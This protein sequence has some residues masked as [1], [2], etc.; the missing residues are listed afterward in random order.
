MTRP[1]SL[2]RKK[3]KKNLRKCRD[4]PRSWFGRIN[5][6][7]K[8]ILPKAIYRINAMPTT[9]LTQFFKDMEREIL[10]FIWKRQTNKQKSRI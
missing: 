5:I 1:S 2:S 6:V 3:S 7:K 4:L 8:A 9:T 10:Y